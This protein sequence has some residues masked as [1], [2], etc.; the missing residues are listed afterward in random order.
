MS[1]NVGNRPVHLEWKSNSERES[2]SVHN[3]RVP[4][5]PDQ[6]LLQYRRAA[7]AVHLWIAPLYCRA[8]GRERRKGRYQAFPERCHSF[9]AADV[10]CRFDERFSADPGGIRADRHER[11]RICYRFCLPVSAG[12][13]CV[14]ADVQLVRHRAYGSGSRIYNGRICVETLEQQSF[15]L[16]LYGSAD[17]SF[18]CLGIKWR[19]VSER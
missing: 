1:G 12:F 10:Y 18:F 8:G 5:D 3:E 19:A 16:G 7:C 15:D 17:P 2:V 14:Q 6:F 13:F 9:F 4:H 11:G